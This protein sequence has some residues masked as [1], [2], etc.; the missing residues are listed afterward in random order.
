MD[1]AP[2]TSLPRL[3]A[4][5]Q[6][7]EPPR[8]AR[9]FLWFALAWGLLLVLLSFALPV[10]TVLTGRDGRQP[11]LSLVRAYGLAGALPAVAILAATVLAA[12]LLGFGR[13]APARAP[14]AWARGI[15]VLTLVV[16][17]VTTATLHI[18]VLILPLALALLLATLLTAP[19]E[20]EK[21]RSAPLPRRRWTP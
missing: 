1:R 20:V 16:A 5:N 14:L 18:G 15:A 6:M 3:P 10:V 19:G 9:V 7:N 21:G 8:P 11:R 12:W 17:L 13:H 2:T 4:V